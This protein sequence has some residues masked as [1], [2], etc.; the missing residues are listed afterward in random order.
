[1]LSTILAIAFLTFNP[2]P[3]LRCPVSASPVEEMGKSSAVFTGKVISRNYMKVEDE[4]GRLTGEERLVVKL[5]VKRVWKGEIKEQILMYTAQMRYSNGRI[6]FM[7]E[8]F[9]F[10]D[11]GH[12]LVYARGPA[13]RLTTSGCTR[14]RELS[15]ANDDLQE[16][17]DSYAPATEQPHVIPSVR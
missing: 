1:M 10:A 8:D 7:S 12:Y 17:G 4:S 5:E 16:L 14:T 13:D 6:F 2:G 15:Q 3:S 9:N 11:H